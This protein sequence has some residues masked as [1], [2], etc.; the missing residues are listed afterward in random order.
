MYYFNYNDIAAIPYKFMRYGMFF[1]YACFTMWVRLR[2]IYVDHDAKCTYYIL[3]LIE[4]IM[5]V[6]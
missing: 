3:L 4:F 1:T 6:T 5:S 2:I